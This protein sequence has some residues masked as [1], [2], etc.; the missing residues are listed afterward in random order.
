MKKIAATALAMLGLVIAPPMAAAPV[1][2]DGN[3][4]Y[5]Q[6]M[7]S[8]GIVGERQGQF[9]MEYIMAQGQEACSALRSG[10]SE[11]SVI[12][13]LEGAPGPLHNTL[14]RA[15]AQ[16]IVFAAHHYLCPGV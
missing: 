12:G 15:Q 5:D 1:H 16:D 11:S 9:T 7:I 4:Q 6:Y 13:Q 3:D 14:G 2:A 8:N 10:S